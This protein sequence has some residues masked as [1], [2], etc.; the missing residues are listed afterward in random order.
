M[1]NQGFF[2][3]K[4]KIFIILLHLTNWEHK[5][6]KNDNQSKYYLKIDIQNLLKFL[7]EQNWDIHSLDEQY[8][9]YV[10]ENY[11]HIHEDLICL[12]MKEI[13]SQEKFLQE[14]AQKEFIKNNTS[15]KYLWIHG[16]ITI[17]ILQALEK[18][19][20]IQIKDDKVCIRFDSDDIL[21]EFKFKKYIENYVTYM[22]DKNWFILSDKFQVD[23]ERFLNINQNNQLTQEEFDSLVDKMPLM[24]ELKKE[25]KILSKKEKISLMKKQNEL[26]KKWAL[27]E[28]FN[29]LRDYLLE[30]IINKMI[31]NKLVYSLK[32]KEDKMF[33]LGKNDIGINVFIDHED[34]LK[35]IASD[36]LDFAKNF[37]EHFNVLSIED[38][39]SKYETNHD[40]KNY[41]F[42]EVN[43]YSNLSNHKKEEIIKILKQGR[44][45]R[46]FI[47]FN[48]PKED[49]KELFNTQYIWN[50]TS[51]YIDKDIKKDKLK[52]IHPQ[53]QKI[54]QKVF[55][56]QSGTKEINEFLI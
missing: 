12:F 34:K 22:D 5:F 51:L 24:I 38:Y 36:N 29:D 52:N 43:N 31:K 35:H 28:T 13:K 18:S 45:Y 19:K 3:F 39:N 2:V 15:N 4:H 9:Q 11:V 25:S 49:L 7:K 1:R 26:L 54:I 14:Y 23:L 10:D 33:K 21:F 30:T 53:L 56:S 42:F 40:K 27:P 32:E 16:E 8:I 55:I 41:I 6:N 17:N 37:K 47:W 50:I 44:S 48:L 46:N 20:N